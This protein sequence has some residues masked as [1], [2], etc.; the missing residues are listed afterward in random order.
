MRPCAVFTGVGGAGESATNNEV[1][2]AL[3]FGKGGRPWPPKLDSTNSSSNLGLLMLREDDLLLVLSPS[4]VP[5]LLLLTVLSL[6]WPMKA[7][8]CL[9]ES[10]YRGCVNP[11]ASPKLFYA[12]KEASRR[13]Q[14]RG[15]QLNMECGR[16]LA[17][18]CGHAGPAWPRR[19]LNIPLHCW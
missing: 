10:K 16:F 14:N 4:S 18:P 1:F 13:G 7:A 15:P 12:R 11:D 17:V 8:I 5:P 3:N 6:P 9:Q 2:L 19:L